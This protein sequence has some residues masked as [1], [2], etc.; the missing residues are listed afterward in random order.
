QIFTL[1]SMAVNTQR[2][3]W[4][5]WHNRDGS[6]GIL[7][8]LFAEEKRKMKKGLRKFFGRLLLITII[9]CMFS[10][11]LTAQK[12]AGRTAITNPSVQTQQ[13]QA[14]AL[15]PNIF[16]IT[17]PDHVVIVIEENHSFSS[18]IGSSQAPF[19]N[20]LARQGALFTQ[21][22]AVGHPSEPNYLELFSG[23][24]QGVTDDSCP[25]TF[26]VENLASELTAAGLTF[27]GFSEDL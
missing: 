7:E 19:I 11:L 23:S 15:A 14:P 25:H 17:P 3:L 24:N 1:F 4:R 27:T 22:F 21:S 12:A 18:I 13:V 2:L 5:A 6:L 16:G 20:S 8:S 26:S 10:S 9:C